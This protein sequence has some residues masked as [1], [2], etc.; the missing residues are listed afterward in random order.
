M[1]INYNPRPEQERYKTTENISEKRVLLS[2]IIYK[3]TE[4]TQEE[5]E[6]F[7]SEVNNI[8]DDKFTELYDFILLNY[9]EVIKAIKLKSS[10]SD[11]I[12]GLDEINNG[13]Q[14]LYRNS[15]VCIKEAGDLYC[16]QETIQGEQI[17]NSYFS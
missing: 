17:L 3:S 16:Q 8:P 14:R 5:K 10:I 11:L 9:G 6:S 7:L 4:L 12:K 2:N 13:I 15:I 1:S